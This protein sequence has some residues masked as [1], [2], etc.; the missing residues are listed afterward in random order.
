MR[1]SCG[2][3][4]MPCADGRSRTTL[5]TRF[6]RVSNTMTRPPAKSAMKRMP[7][8][9]SRLCDSKRR[10]LPSR[11]TSDT[12][13]SGNGIGAPA[14][15]KGTSA[16]RASSAIGRGIVRK[17]S[18]KGIED[19]A[20]FGEELA[21]VAGAIARSGQDDLEAGRFRN[22]G[23]AD[24]EGVDHGTDSRQRRI[25][26]VSERGHEHLERRHGPDVG[27]RR[28]V[29]VETDG[30]RGRLAIVLQ[31]LERRIRIDEPADEPGARDAVD[32]HVRPRYPQPV[33]EFFGSALRDRSIHGGRLV[34][35][36]SLRDRIVQRRN[37]RLGAI[38]TVTA[39]EVDRLDPR[40]LA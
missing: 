27:K 1:L 9:A 15:R 10:V 19:V 29:V 34:R 7:V 30:V 35:R 5:T 25:L 32:P 3:T 20:H 14:T 8:V 22:A 12:T 36:K 18:V 23:A 2:T 16:T 33:A 13:Y 40:Q 31:P 37:E 24:V 39:E 11:G 4:T 28:V 26:A 6:F 38:A 17:R 21:V